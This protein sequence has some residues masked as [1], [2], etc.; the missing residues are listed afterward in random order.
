MICDSYLPVVH[1]FNRYFQ[2]NIMCQ[3]V[4][5]KRAVETS[6]VWPQR[7]H[8]CRKQRGQRRNKHIDVRHKICSQVS[9]IAIKGGRQ[10]SAVFEK[11]TEWAFS[12]E[13]MSQP[14][15][16]EVRSEHLRMPGEQES[17]QR[18]LPCKGPEAGLFLKGGKT[19]RVRGGGVGCRGS[20]ERT[21]MRGVWWKMGPTDPR[22]LER[23]PGNLPQQP[24]SGTLTNV[25]G[26]FY[27]YWTLENPFLYFWCQMH[28][29][30]T[31][32]SFPILCIHQGTVLQ[33]HSNRTA[34]S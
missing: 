27:I 13:V 19:G 32:S 26:P 15:L 29:F 28:E 10:P 1:S 23:P 21:V 16:K 4:Y 31:R 7:F 12:M 2:E 5:M 17:R 6:N 33:F 11:K 34:Q 9:I 22:N 18:E 20:R 30:F 24:L 25:A 14:S 3:A 8:E